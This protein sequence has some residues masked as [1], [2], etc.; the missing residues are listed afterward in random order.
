MNI[1]T[2]SPI[3]QKAFEQYL[4]RGTPIDISLKALM[5]KAAESR[6]NHTTTHYIWRTAGDGKV[7]AG[8]AANE[9]RIIAWNN[10][11]PTGHPREDY[12]CRCWAEPYDPR[13]SEYVWQRVISIVDEGL[14]RREW[15]D[16]IRHFYDGNGQAVSLASAGHLQDVI[17][18]AR[19]P[20]SH[21][22]FE[23]IEKQ[24]IAQARSI[25][26][27]ALEG[28]SSNSYN[29]SNVSYVHGSSTV[30]TNYTGSV[31]DR[32]GI[33]IIRARIQ[34][35]FEDVFTDPLSIRERRIGTST[36]HSNDEEGEV[37]G[38]AYRIYGT[39]VTEL[40]AAIHADVRHSRYAD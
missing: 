14:N 1:T 25:R 28:S 31:T 35:T 10:A 26:S 9:G 33:L 17:D 37:G 4:R 30:N 7:R 22:V 18:H 34:Y 36:P 2:D 16:F 6:E 21:Q 23:G 24:I 27:G 5:T 3:Y 11:P 13:V 12:G 20:G 40:Q 32:D 15:D 39:W 19:Q 8:H 38:I 29:F